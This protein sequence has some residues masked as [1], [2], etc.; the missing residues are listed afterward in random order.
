MAR[1]GIILSVIWIIGLGGYA[2]FSSLRQLNGLHGLD[3]R[4]CSENLER[5]G[6]S[7]NYEYCLEEATDRYHSRFNDYRERV[8]RLLVTNLEWIALCW[9]AGLGGVVIVRLVRGGFRFG[10]GK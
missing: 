6:N 3:L 7:V 5:T 2:G 4:A 9:L 1:I 10:R 8:L